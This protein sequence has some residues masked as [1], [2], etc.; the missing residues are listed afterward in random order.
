MNHVS[1]LALA[2]TALLSLG[3]SASACDNSSGAAS[4]GASDSGASNTTEDGGAATSGAALN[5]GYKKATWGSGVTVT[6]G[7]CTLRYQSNGLPNHT[8]D[9][10]YAVPNT[11]V[12][13]PTSATAHAATD[14]TTT[15][16]YD[17]TL[18]TCPTPQAT[19]TKTSLDTISY[20]I[21]GATLFNAYEG[22]SSTVALSSNFS[23]DN[24]S[25]TKVYFVDTC[26][27]HPTPMGK[28]HYHGL[29]ACVTAEVD[30][31]NGPS[32]IIGI[33]LDGYPVYGNRDANGAE[34]TASQLDECNGITSATPE[35]PAGVYHYVLPNTTDAT[36]SIRC[37]KGKVTA[38]SSTGGMMGPP[39]GGGPPGTD[40]GMA[41]RETEGCGANSAL[42]L[43]DPSL[44]GRLLAGVS[45]SLREPFWKL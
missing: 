7:D 12:I 9:A 1:K 14:P 23:V 35:F 43:R 40:G 41:L 26:N 16:T 39:P 17:I 29:P 11:G 22:D 18:N 31:A 42:A 36:S 20:M 38:T 30:T 25:G 45:R 15:Q 33:A 44:S 21:S 4:S 27:G 5:D 37:Y 8:R 3:A 24:S 6:Y 19:T 10:E 13:V 28:Y 2:G 32:H 34:V